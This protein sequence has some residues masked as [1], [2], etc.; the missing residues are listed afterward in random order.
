MQSPA[1]SPSR[2]RH[3]VLS[4]AE[5]GD[6]RQC[7]PQVRSHP[8]RP[9]LYDDGHYPIAAYGRAERAVG[10]RSEWSPGVLAD[11]FS[12]AAVRDC[13]ALTE[14]DLNA[15]TERDVRAG[16]GLLTK[17]GSWNESW[18]GC[19]AHWV[20]SVL[21]ERSA[22]P[23]VQAVR[24]GRLSM[25]MVRRRSTVRFRK[26][27]PGGLHIWPVSM[28][29]FGTDTRLRARMILGLPARGAESPGP[30]GWRERW[31]TPGTPSRNAVGPA[32]S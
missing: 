7:R 13:S 3:P 11:R 4:S 15:V 22:V 32:R 29:T 8:D 6:G 5:P 30:A 21:P 24:S 26:G 25:A 2:T 27:A 9:D 17:R 12:G 28:F 23:S 20:H 14:H 31:P 1:T 19:L 10:A 18:T 16:C